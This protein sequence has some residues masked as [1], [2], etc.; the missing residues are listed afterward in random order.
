M[1]KQIEKLEKFF[2][3]YLILNPILDI[4]SGLYIQFVT[5]GDV[6]SSASVAPVTPS[7]IV[8]M[9]VLL[10]MIGYIF[11]IKDWKS[12]KIAIPMGVAWALSVVSEFITFGE[13]SLFIDVQYFAR[14]AY[15]VAVFS[16]T[17][18]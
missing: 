6:Y 16:Y 14:F 3:F 12:V 15:N 4:V 7:L 10:V 9:A 13:L 17:A 8:R 2:W 18:V 5:H 11:L 1:S